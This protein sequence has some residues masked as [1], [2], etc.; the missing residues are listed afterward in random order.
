[1]SFAP[2]FFES[3]ARARNR[4]L[5]IDSAPQGT[6]RVSQHALTPQA[7]DTTRRTWMRPSCHCSTSITHGLPARAP[8]RLRMPSHVGSAWH[9][10]LT[11]RHTHQSIERENPAGHCVGATEWH[12][13]RD[14]PRRSGSRMGVCSSVLPAQLSRQSH[15]IR[16]YAEGKKMRISKEE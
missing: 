2:F 13:E 14:G 15:S 3:R 5:P 16:H 7:H 8:R 4:T 10:T 11:T 9:P 6:D 1:M 12:R